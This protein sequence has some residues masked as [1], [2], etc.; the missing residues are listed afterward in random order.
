V[1]GICL[2]EPAEEKWKRTVET[3]G[4]YAQFLNC[5]G[6]VDGKHIRIN[7]PPHSGSLYYNYK[8]YL[9]YCYLLSVM[10]ITSSSALMLE[11]T[12]SLT[13]FKDSAIYEKL[14]NKELQI[15]DNCPI[16]TTN[17]TPMPHVFVGDEAFPVLENLMCPYPSNNLSAEKKIL[18][19]RLS[20]ARRYI[21]CTFDI[22]G[23]L[24]ITQLHLHQRWHYI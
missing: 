15:P 5:I 14:V 18:N 20:H 8:R 7:Q 21:K 24:C 12:E 17:V 10:Q 1:K 13:I 23:M 2:C 22:L 6:G 19:Y 16:S 4:N 9:S 11:H 3:F